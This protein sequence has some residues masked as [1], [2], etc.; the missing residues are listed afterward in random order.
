MVAVPDDE[1]YIVI[2]GRRWRRSDPSLPEHVRVALV[3]EL[4]A[5]R[6]AVGA[7]R[8]DTAVRDARRRVDA[9]KRALGERGPRWWDPVTPDAVRRRVQALLEALGPWNGYEW[10]RSDLVAAS[11]AAS[12]PDGDALVDAVHTAGAAPPGDAR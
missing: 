6:R 9:A 5:A 4:M 1:R 8:S 3:S 2:D 11:H 12:V 10:S 7:A